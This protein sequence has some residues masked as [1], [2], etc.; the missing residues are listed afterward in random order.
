MATG[1]SGV[2]AGTT[3]TT[4]LLVVFRL[5]PSVSVSVSAQLTAAVAP[6]VS[7]EADGLGPAVI[8]GVTPVKVLTPEAH[9]SCQVYL[10]S[11]CRRGL[12]HRN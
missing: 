10:I 5:S 9:A 1:G 4:V 6:V 11:L 12:V 8:G 2:G 3:V 7:M